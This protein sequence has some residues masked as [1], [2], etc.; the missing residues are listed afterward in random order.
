M[1]TTSHIVG[2][3]F[4]ICMVHMAVGQT[5]L[6]VGPPRVFYIVDA[7]QSQTQYVDVTNPSKDYTL[8][9]AVSLED[10]EYS[11]VGDNV[12][13]PGGSLQTSCVDWLSI[14]EP[15]FALKPGESKR[16]QVNMQVPKEISYSDSIP[17]HTAML[18]VTQLN[19]RAGAEQEGANIRL[20]VRAGIKIYHGFNR[21]ANTDLEITNLKY[22]TLDQAGKFLELSYDVTG[23]TWM[24]GQIR[25]EFINQDNGKKTIVEDIGFYCLPHDKRKQYISV[26]QELV[27]GDY[28]ATVM[29][30]YGDQ[31]L[32]KAAELEFKYE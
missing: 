18:F 30:F 24:E 7:G 6:T 5:G 11:E 19:P 3:F 12:I 4:A 1:K 13:K 21:Q 27:A 14:S 22:T 32:V 25:A 10:W 28:I 8:E 9:L 23:N 16:L 2:V 20:A 31:N 15:F 26:P 17:V 29:L